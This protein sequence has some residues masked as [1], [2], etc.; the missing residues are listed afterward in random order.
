MQRIPNRYLRLLAGLLCLSLF[1]ACAATAGAQ[2]TGTTTTPTPT[3][4]DP[5][6]PGA[7]VAAVAN[8][9]LE[10]TL[11]SSGTSSTTTTT[12]TTGG[13]AY[14]GIAT[15]PTNPTDPNPSTLFPAID[16]GNYTTGIANPNSPNVIWYSPLFLRIDGGINI[17][18]GLDIAVGD[19]AFGTYTVLPRTLGSNSIFFV[20]TTF[21]SLNLIAGLP[22]ISVAV[23]ATLIHDTVRFQF[24][25]SNTES[26]SAHTIGFA[27]I[28][29]INAQPGSLSMDGP[30][31]LPGLPVQHTATLLN[32]SQV[33]DYYQ[34][35][36]PVSVATSSS[37]AIAHTVRGTMLP[38]NG[39]TTEPTPPT[40]IAYGRQF[41][42][43]PFTTNST[44]T[45]TT[46]SGLMVPSPLESIQVI[47]EA[48]TNT[49]TTT[50]TSGTISYATPWEYQPLPNDYLDRASLAL[51]PPAA[52]GLFWDEQTVVAGEALNYV[53]Y[54]GQGTGDVDL[55][56]PLALTVESPATLSYVSGTAQPNAGAS[57]TTTNPFTVTASVQNISDILS[58]GA[59]SIG[60][61]SMFI[62]LPSSLTLDA[63]TANN[64]A[65]KQ[66]TTLP[67][68]AEQAVSWAVDTVGSVSGPE[69]FNVSAS[70]T[71]GRA[72]QIER[73][74]QVP[75]LPTVNLAQGL[76][77]VS[78]P[79]TFSG[80]NPAADLGVPASTLTP[81]LQ[82]WDSVN[83]SYKVATTILPGVG[84]WLNSSV[85]QTAKLASYAPLTL[86]TSSGNQFTQS[87]PPGVDGWNQIGNPYVYNIQFSDI[88]ILN[89]QTL[90]T[91]TTDVASDSSHQWISQGLYAYDPTTESYT[92]E[93]NIGFTMVPG[94][95]YWMQVLSPNLQFIFPV[96][97][98]VGAS[99]TRAVTRAATTSTSTTTLGRD[100]TNNW[101]LQ[102]SAKGA[103]TAD[104]SYIGVAPTAVDGPDVFKYQKP[105]V[106]NNHVELNITHTD[107]GTTRAAT[108]Y[109]QD[110]RSPSVAIKTWNMTVVAAQASEPVTITWP[111][112]STS[113]PRAYE[114][115]LID[116]A[117]NKRI[118]MRNTSSYVV[119]TGKSLTR[120][121]QIVAEPTRAA[122]RL[123]ITSFTVVPNGIR[124]GTRAPASV[125]IN[126]TLSQTA[127]AQI[128][129][130]DSLGRN[131]RT[132]NTTTRAAGTGGQPAGSAVW[133]FRNQKGVA[134]STGLYSVE[135]DAM[136]SD[137]QKSRMTVPYL[138]AR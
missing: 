133:D 107:W 16:E 21:P 95:G 70:P 114:L 11:T 20:Y 80:A 27:F 55:A 56:P 64:T 103:K 65:S 58:T 97:N 112:L 40:H 24:V 100:T 13:V 32:G 90:E 43:S 48:T 122:T 78:F 60:P 63:G 96:I 39:A 84:Y 49:S 35:Q 67:S 52:V 113:V 12:T 61:V 76:Q 29:N 37:P 69:S 51:Y 9:Y 92:L 131:L 23:T 110:L 136:T 118:S 50:T 83:G 106:L 1:V 59:I 75:F 79:Y 10:L 127:D 30:L 8:S 34:T 86:P 26:G 14:F 91:V 94:Q 41:W 45:T 98:A 137:G 124:P 89:T 42:V 62:N 36:V 47:F 123:Q 116:T 25:I 73:T 108:P 38:F 128:V 7:I 33:P 68:E 101:R 74:L 71:L 93:T 115:T 81:G 53:T 138:L 121:I 6:V 126:Y 125:Q 132:L 109:A 44:S 129:V 88:Q 111:S 15:T 82:T 134:L 77:M 85:A 66:I 87:Y 54:V 28:E 102:V 46:T 135:I 22:S 72:K 119:T 120:N 3:A 17:E 57:T 31:I 104:S 4:T 19:A 105:P 5:R 130:R 18:N 99:V 117:G 2:T